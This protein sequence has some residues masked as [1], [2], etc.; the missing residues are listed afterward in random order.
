MFEYVKDLKLKPRLPY[1]KRPKTDLIILHHFASD[2]S[3]SA[4]HEAHMSLAHGLH[5]GID[6][7]IVV[8]LDGQAV[9]GRGLE[10]EGGHVLNSGKSAGMNKRS[11]GIACQGNF[12]MRTM[13]APQK[14]TLFRVILDCLSAYPEIKTILGHKEV[15]AT[16]CP[17]RNYPL[18]EAK[19]L[20]NERPNTVKPKPPAAAGGIYRVRK[21]WADAAS[22]LGAF[23]DF[24][25]AK[26]LA[27]KHPGYFVYDGNTNKVYPPTQ[28]TAHPVAKANIL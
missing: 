7:N 11:I 22:Q 4:V 2:A 21:S 12:E 10:Y 8:Q 27:D 16:A 13:P 25:N 5:R 3:A 23:K 24:D 26:A 15:K 9:W 28:A 6:Y 1:A 18:A 20:L 14:E 17:G 19:A